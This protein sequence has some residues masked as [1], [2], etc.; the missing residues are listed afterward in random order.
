MDPK[1]SVG[2]IFGRALRLRCPR[3]G[4]DKMFVNLIHMNKR[5][6][7][8]DLK[9]ERSPGYFLGSMYVNYGLTSIIMTIGYV[10]LHFGAGIANRTLTPWLI[11]FCI[12]FPTLFFR[13]ARSLWMA[14]DACFDTED[15]WGESSSRE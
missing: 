8:C 13:Y 14:M 9:Y 3:C 6:S 1:P 10:S 5:C 2:T 15:F 4:Q 12:V 11:G 7:R